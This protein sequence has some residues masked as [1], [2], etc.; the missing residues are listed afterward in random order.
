MQH[1]AKYDRIGKFNA[2]AAACGERA[3]LCVDNPQEVK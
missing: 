2:A 1:A 3:S